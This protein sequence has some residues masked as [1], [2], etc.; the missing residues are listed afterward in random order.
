M[1]EYPKKLNI[2]T[3]F[4]TFHFPVYSSN[5]VLPFING[6]KY[7]K[8]FGGDTFSSSLSFISDNQYDEL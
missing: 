6:L 5:V 2:M 8:C 1:A 4:G 7:L 3:D